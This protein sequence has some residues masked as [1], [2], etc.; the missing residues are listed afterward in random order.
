MQNMSEG[1]D[2]Y[3][4]VGS[5]SS[6]ALHSFSR[7]RIIGA[8]EIGVTPDFQITSKLYAPCANLTFEGKILPIKQDNN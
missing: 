5:G 3:I 6:G 2:C 8:K 4:E 1:F 7:S